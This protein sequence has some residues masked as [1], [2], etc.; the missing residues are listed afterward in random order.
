[1]G[2]VDKKIGFLYSITHI[3][4]YPLNAFQS[5]RYIYHLFVVCGAMHVKIP[6]VLYK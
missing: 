1:M 2:V 4:A 6:A 5:A 3:H